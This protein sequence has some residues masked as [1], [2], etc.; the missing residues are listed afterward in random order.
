MRSAALD[1]SDD[2]DDDATA[3]LTPAPQNGA[4]RLTATDRSDI[5][6]DA[7]AP[8]MSPL[9]HQTHEKMTVC[10][11]PAVTDQCDDDS[12]TAVPP[13]PALL[14]SAHETTAPPEKAAPVRL[15]AP[16]QSDDADDDAAALLAPAPEHEV[17]TDAQAEAIVDETAARNN[18]TAGLE[19][20]PDYRGMMP[21]GPPVQGSHGTTYEIKCLETIDLRAD[22]DLLPRPLVTSAI[23]LMLEDMKRGSAE[24]SALS[25]APEADWERYW[26]ENMS[27]VPCCAR[28]QCL[29]EHV[30]KERLSNLPEPPSVEFLI[31][32][33]HECLAAV[34][35]ELARYRD[36]RSACGAARKP[37]TDG[38]FLAQLSE[39]DRL[40]VYFVREVWGSMQR[41][42]AS[43]LPWR[44]LDRHVCDYTCEG[45]KRWIAGV[46]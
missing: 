20:M 22:A 45:R 17:K 40:A 5:A 44:V 6:G 32:M 30:A 1:Q 26:S 36:L 23:P 37:D 43:I 18:S 3:P 34:R 35:K 28:A 16:D 4:V 25:G 46:S 14:H 8:P 13:T 15:A 24:P 12:D 38:T 27:S 2:A 7:A 10:V 9:R 11:R 31:A 19:R 33:Q 21:R 39:L 41:N 42:R 29:F